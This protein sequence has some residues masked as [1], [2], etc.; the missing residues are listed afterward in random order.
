[1]SINT[2]QAAQTLRCA[3]LHFMTQA[4]TLPTFHCR[5]LLHLVVGGAVDEAADG[6]TRIDDASIVW[7]EGDGAW[8]LDLVSI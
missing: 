7:T 8:D 6:L 4:A 5:T 2:M 1:M 3:V